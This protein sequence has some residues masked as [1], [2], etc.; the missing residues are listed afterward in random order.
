MRRTTSQLTRRGFLGLLSGRKA[1]ARSAPWSAPAWDETTWDGP[2]SREG[3]WAGLPGAGLARRVGPWRV[4]LDTERCLAWGGADCRMCFIACPLRGTAL[5]FEAE[6]PH[7]VRAGCDDCGACVP[8]C[9]IVNDRRA[10]H[11]E[12]CEAADVVHA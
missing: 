6:R 10:L 9:G 8:A 11:C 1:T 5:V 4:V 12:R 7:L 3:S 2:A